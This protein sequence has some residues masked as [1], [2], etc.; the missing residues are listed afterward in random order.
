MNLST[1]AIV[2]K[3]TVLFAIA[4]PILFAK[5]VVI[6]IKKIFGYVLNIGKNMQEIEKIIK[7]G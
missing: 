2:R 3:G 6:I 5:I 1:N 7:N 4:Y